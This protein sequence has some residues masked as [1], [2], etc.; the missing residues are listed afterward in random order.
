MPSSRDTK[1]T[2]TCRATR[3][4]RLR[5][6][7]GRRA[8]R[9]RPSGGQRENS[10]GSRAGI[11]RH[12]SGGRVIRSR[13][14]TQFLIF[15]SSL[16]SFPLNLFNPAPSLSSGV[17]L[18]SCS[19]ERSAIMNLARQLTRGT[20]RSANGLFRTVS[21]Q[22]SA[23]NRL[24]QRTYSVKL[25]ATTDPRLPGLDPSKLTIT[26]TTTPKEP[27]P[28]QELVFGKTFTGEILCQCIAHRYGS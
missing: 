8:G 24:W 19:A 4:S 12:S 16:L 2:L 23:A 10:A 13:G 27:L 18:P 21:L 5:A 15:S 9:T 3:Q 26:K 25:E 22:S 28:P 1:P 6:H 14:V 11:A 20:P 17:I 7:I